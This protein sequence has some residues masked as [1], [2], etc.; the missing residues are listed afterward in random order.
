MGWHSAD[1]LPP[2]PEG[3]DGAEIVERW[4]SNPEINEHNCS[5]FWYSAAC[6]LMDKGTFHIGFYDYIECQWM[7]AD[8]SAGCHPSF[9][10]PQNIIVEKW[11]LLSECGQPGL[12]AYQQQAMQTAIYPKQHRVIYPALKLNGEAGEVA[13]HVGKA[14]RDDGGDITDESREAII[15]EIGD[16]LWYVAALANDLDVSLEE[17]AQQNIKKLRFR[18][19]RGALG[20]SGDER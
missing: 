6:L 9:A 15:K 5:T 16:V 8:N 19:E 13:E 2:C 4:K 12:N 7:T 1:E 11:C 18:Q 10:V 17:I 14:L 3:Q 20:G